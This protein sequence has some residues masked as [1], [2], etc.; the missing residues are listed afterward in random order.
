MIPATKKAAVRIV[1][2][3]DANGARLRVALR[4]SGVCAQH[5]AP[6]PITNFVIKMP[7]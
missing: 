5:V 6:P 2:L 1:T 7:M 3:L 4:A